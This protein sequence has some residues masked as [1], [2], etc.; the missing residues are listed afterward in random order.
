MAQPLAVVRNPNNPPLFQRFVAPPSGVTRFLL[1]DSGL[2]MLRK[3]MTPAAIAILTAMGEPV[4]K[5]PIRPVLIIPPQIL[6]AEP[7]VMIGQEMQLASPDQA[8]VALPAIPAVSGCGADGTVFNLEPPANARMQNGESVDFI[9][10]GV[11]VGADLVVAGASDFRDSFS[12]L[13]GYYVHRATTGC[14]PTFEGALP[15]L[16]GL[17]GEAVSADG[18]PVVAADPARAAFFIADQH[19]GSNGSSGTTAIGL[20]RT[21]SASLLSAATCPG[22][23]HNAAQAASCWPQRVLVNP[24]P[25]PMGGYQQ[26]MPSLAV[27]QRAAGV[28]AGDLY[29]TATEFDFNSNTSRSWLVACKNNL[30]VCSAPT[31][32]TGYD[33]NTTFTNVQVRPDGRI[34]ITY[35]TQATF[36][37]PLD[38]KFV[39]CKP[40][41]APFTPGCSPPVLV[42]H[43]TQ[44]LAGTLAGQFDGILTNPKHADRLNGG[45]TQTF[46]VWDRCRVASSFLCPDANLLMKYSNDGGVTWGGPFNV[47][48]SPDDQFYPSVTTDRS[49]QTITIAYL[50][51]HIDPQFQ[52][53]FRLNLLQ[54]LPGS[55]TAPIAVTSTPDDPSSEGGGRREL[56]DTIGLA[57]R[58]TG[59]AGASRIY[60]AYSYHLRPGT[61]DG[62]SG[63]QGDNYL[64]RLT[65]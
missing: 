16:V 3:R 55:L 2:R 9:Y 15:N 11:G 61:Y 33:L 43:E 23:T 53:R 21:T 38:I 34:T 19:L 4:P 56:G 48:V 8:I 27:D 59:A 40:A 39:S 42:V 5:D 13:S 10:N 41:G 44:P 47:D 36:G 14:A 31:F 29:L 50:N 26:E 46:L 12:G 63:P 37:D 52:H 24:L 65:Y 60:G 30:S 64:T 22:G 20:F 18:N 57:V 25:N 49:T 35:L 1:S 51:N 54:I 28:G 45:I 58:G 32:I 62:I 17:S 7:Q 6:F